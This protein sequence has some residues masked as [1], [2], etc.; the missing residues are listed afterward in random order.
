[1][2]W[3]FPK[4]TPGLRE[5]FSKCKLSANLFM[6]PFANATERVTFLTFDIE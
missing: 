3:A 4:K 6:P 5:P 1:M 2:Q